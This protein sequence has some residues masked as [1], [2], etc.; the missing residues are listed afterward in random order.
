MNEALTIEQAKTLKAGT[1][2]NNDN[3]QPNADGTPRRFKVTSVKTWKRDS[4]RI[5]IRVSR[6]LY[7]HYRWT[8]ASFDYASITIQPDPFLTELLIQK[9]LKEDS[10]T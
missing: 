7:E 6:G 4:G 5:E 1:I 9:H 2:L 10:A 3:Y 8:E